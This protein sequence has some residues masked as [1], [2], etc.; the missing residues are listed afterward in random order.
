ML[1]VRTPMGNKT[2]AKSTKHLIMEI[3]ISWK[4]WRTQYDEQVKSP[5]SNSIKK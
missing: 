5:Q 1:F 3:T 4:K 2:A